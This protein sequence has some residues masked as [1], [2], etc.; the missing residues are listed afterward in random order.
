MIFFFQ[1]FWA[2]MYILNRKSIQ[3]VNICEIIESVKLNKHFCCDFKKL[4]EQVMC[5]ENIFSILNKEVRNY[6][7]K[8]LFKHLFHG[9]ISLR[10]GLTIRSKFQT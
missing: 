2:K 9:V 1:V 10:F 3:N 5:T 7:F 8:N 6:L 4:F